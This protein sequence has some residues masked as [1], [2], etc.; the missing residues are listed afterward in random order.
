MKE[1]Q[2]FKHVINFINSFDSTYSKIALPYLAVLDE[3]NK[4]V[5]KKA[6]EI[7]EDAL[8]I[9]KKSVAKEYFDEFKNIKIDKIRKYLNE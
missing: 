9:E 6:L 5:Y 1:F 3:E 2:R 7:D 8:Q 4:I